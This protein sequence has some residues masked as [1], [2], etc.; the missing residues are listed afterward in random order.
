MLAWALDRLSPQV[1]E[2]LI[3]ANQHLERYA[4]F[5]HPVVPDAI[6]GF[7]G[8]LAGLHAALNAADTEWV[9]TVPCDSPFLPADLVERLAA[10]AA[11]SRAEIAVAKAD[12]RLQPVF[13]LVSTALLPDLADYLA[14]EG[15]KIDRWF[16]TRR[17]VEVEFD[18]AS[19]FVNINTQ[20]ELRRHAQP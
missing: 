12:G 4:R 20:E 11:S 10:S 15:R 18:D 8:P 19:G 16:S 2:V 17:C 6:S 7:V 1:G 9:V 5:G 14:N 3:N 13:A